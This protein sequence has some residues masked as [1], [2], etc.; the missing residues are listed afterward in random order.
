MKELTVFEQIETNGGIIPLI[1]AVP[2]IAKGV[3]AIATG[4]KIIKATG[5]VTAPAV[6]H[7]A[8]GSVATTGGVAVSAN[9]I[10]NYS[11]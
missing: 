11:R 10:R 7:I 4:V 5:T 9:Y 2:L 3:K 6:A 1:A 8:A